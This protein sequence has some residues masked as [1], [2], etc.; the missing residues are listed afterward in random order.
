MNRKQ[1][2]AQMVLAAQDACNLSGV[3][4]SWSKVILPFLSTEKFKGMDERNRHPFS[5]LLA[6]KC[7]ALAGYEPLG[8]PD[9][10]KA[11]STVTD[12]AEGKGTCM[13]DIEMCGSFAECSDCGKK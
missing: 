6:Y 3:V 1:E 12:W 7:M 4:H 5:I 8:C 9:F 2:I 13:K 10:D 11:F